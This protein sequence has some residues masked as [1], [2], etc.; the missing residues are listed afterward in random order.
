MRTS[1][2][3]HCFLYF[4]VL[5]RSL[6]RDDPALPQQSLSL[7]CT[8]VARALRRLAGTVNLVPSLFDRTATGAAAAS[9]SSPLVE[10]GEGALKATLFR[11]IHTLQLSFTLHRLSAA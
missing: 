6:P 3:V 8:M 7:Q 1:Q 11:W 4:H 2:R 5:L 10:A 9:A